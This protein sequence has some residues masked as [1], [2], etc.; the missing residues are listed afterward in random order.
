MRGS[1]VFFVAASLLYACST[2]NPIADTEDDGDKGTGGGQGDDS[3][4]AGA[5]NDPETPNPTPETC[6]KTADTEE[7]CS[8]GV[9]DDCDGFKDCRDS[10][11][12][13]QQCGSDEGLTC[14]AGACLGEAPGLPDLPEVQNVRVFM[15]ADTAR[16]EFEPIDAAKD[17]RIY[18]LP[19]DD[20]ILAG[21]NGEVVVKNAIYRCSGDRPFVKR[22]D[23]PAG[24]YDA[25]LTADVH[26]YKRSESENILGYAFTTPG[27]DREPVYRLADPKGA[28]G[29]AWD[30]IVPLGSEYNSA[31]YVIGEEARDALVK[32]GYR[33]DG[34]AFY[35]PTAGTR[36]VYRRQY[37]GEDGGPESV[38]FYV[39]GPEYDLHET[40]SE[41]VVDFGE[42]FRLLDSA[43]A[44]AVPVYRV[45]YLATNS[46]D[47]L[48]AGQARYERALEQGNLPLWS[49][50]W[51]GL[52]AKT[53]LV[54][55][56]LD[57]G[58][59]FPNGYISA[60]DAPGNPETDAHYPSITLDEARLESGEV[61]VNG[62]HDPNNRPKPI[63]RAFVDVTPE[64]KPD[65]DWYEDF[66]ASTTW[67]PFTEENTFNNGIFLRKND[68]WLVE[69]TGCGEGNTVGPVLSQ[70]VFGGGDYG[71][72]CNM[73][74]I[75]RTVTPELKS[76]SYLHVRMTTEI[77]ST[78]RRYPQ[79]LLT[80]VGTLNV[81]DV[82]ENDVAV[83]NRLGP[84]PF[85]EDYVPHS[86]TDQTLIVQPFSSAHELQIQFC[87]GRGWGVSAQ[88]P[89]ANIYGFPAG[90]YDTEWTDDWR[91]VPALGE[92]A[93]H[94]RPVRFDAYFST[95]R[96]YVTVDGK[97]AGCA[98]LPEGR[99]PAGPVTPIFGSVI[100]HGGIDES[101]TGETSP[102]QYLRSYSLQHYDRKI[103]DMGIDADAALPPWDES[104]LPCATRWYGAEE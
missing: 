80:T 75:P 35:A 59:P 97:P 8:D 86:G 7:N 81:G 102:H 39:P 4:Q 92:M 82:N 63:A 89:R 49:L 47:V 11:C 91:P 93:G 2:S 52:T 34:I 96:V 53:T 12:G 27:P 46:F 85:A 50:T 68:T 90:S 37:P 57:Q 26:G 54:I 20:D 10:E 5:Q 65:M 56:A 28:G 67:A 99:M 77:P 83:R 29:Y 103:D 74:I 41:E 51:T 101:V 64:A 100:Y 6:E 87:D 61:F 44:G 18:P 40:Q 78:F 42:R 31:D 9:D 38:I 36:P 25:S 17:Y 98:I 33:D 84:L 3:A 45:F 13:G 1:I 88:C 19:S 21:E 94:D 70:L 14:Q 15:N 62:Q 22:K 23:D 79:I 69:Y 95:E 58:C 73:S 71:S 55:E 72:S 30:Y 60:F 104:V 76:G 66:G 43:T 16:V 48:A 24:F 32:K